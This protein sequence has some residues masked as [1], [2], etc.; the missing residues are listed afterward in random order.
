[1]KFCIGSIELD[2]L[3]MES[4]KKQQQQQRKNEEEEIITTKYTLYGTKKSAV[5]LAES[6]KHV[7]DWKR[8]LKEAKKSNSNHTLDHD[9]TL[10]YTR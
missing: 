8:F 3:W 9:Y 5:Y 2:T 4:W 10:S 1:M 6:N 7:N